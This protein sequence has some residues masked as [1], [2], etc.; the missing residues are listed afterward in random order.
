MINP[1]EPFLSYYI[2]SK[3]I[4]KGIPVSG[5]FELTRRC[6][7]GCRMCYVHSE[8]GNEDELSASEWLKTARQAR[9]NGM[10]FLL[11]TGGEPFLRDDFAQIYPALAEMG[12]VISINTNG[13]LYDKAREVLQKY[14]PMRLN[15]SLYGAS[16]ETYGRLCG[17]NAF[18][19]V[20]DN[21]RKMKK[22]G[23]RVRINYSAVPENAGE[24]RAVHAL[25]A[26][27]GVPVRFA[28]YVFPRT[29]SD[30]NAG[31]RLTPEKSAKALNEWK[32]INGREESKGEEPKEC[33]SV[34]TGVACR[35]GRSAFWITWDGKMLPCGT[36]NVKGISLRDVSFDRAWEETRSFV[37]SIVL[38]SECAECG[39]R[40]KCGVC[41][42]V[43]LAETGEFNIR[44]EYMCRMTEA[45][46]RGEDQT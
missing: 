16:G 2:N 15:V 25:S 12:F 39:M 30:N 27:L 17:S 36:M 23:H 14:P 41:A 19:R 44:P 42:S 20:K 18:E 38:P 31:A 5:T 7:F 4:E 9:E 40:R 10:I 24:I 13:S 45:I 29:R 46:I 34:G 21:I 11:L 32:V 3:G 6:N 43:C 1:G 33:P 26:G 22:D 37:K 35:A 8:S 28:P